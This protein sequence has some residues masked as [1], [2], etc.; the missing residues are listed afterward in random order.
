[1]KTFSSRW[2]YAC[3]KLKVMRTELMGPEPHGSPKDHEVKKTCNRK[4]GGR[5][6]PE[7]LSVGGDVDVEHLKYHCAANVVV[8]GSHTLEPFALK[9]VLD[10]SSSVTGISER[11][12]K[13]TRGH[14]AGVQLSRLLPGERC[15]W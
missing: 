1:M 4:V 13:W 3:E 8:P 14:F 15:Q 12:L 10:S 5:I 6:S 7:G 9:V 2:I 11:L